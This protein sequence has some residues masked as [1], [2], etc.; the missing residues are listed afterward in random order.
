MVI[1]EKEE[2]SVII[3]QEDT[4]K[5]TYNIKNFIEK[6]LIYYELEKRNDEMFEK[7]CQKCRQEEED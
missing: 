7:K 4:K 5:R 1:V 2:G 6:L 3:S